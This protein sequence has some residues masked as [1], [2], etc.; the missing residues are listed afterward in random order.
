MTLEDKLE[1]FYKSAVEDAKAQ[2]DA[3]INEYEASLEKEFSVRRADVKRQARNSYRI[4]KEELLRDKNKKLS[5]AAKDVK[6]QVLE[7]EKSYAEIL[8]SLVETK[9]REYMKTEAYENKLAEQILQAKEI[10]DGAELVLYINASDE[11][12][13]S[14]LEEKT[15]TSI[16]ISTIEFIGGMRAVIRSNNILIDNSFFTKLAEEK[17]TYKMV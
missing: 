4:E 10:A 1:L 5:Q 12:K 7:E 13:K 2:S 15:G 14:S 11:E 16:S 6:R 8:F 9:I 3:L 17:E